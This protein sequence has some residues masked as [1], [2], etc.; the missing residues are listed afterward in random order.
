MITKFITTKNFIGRLLTI[1]GLDSTS[2]SHLFPQM[3]EDAISII[4][5]PDYYINKDASIPIINH[6]GQLPCDIEHAHSFWVGKT[7][8][9]ESNATNLCRLII[10]NNPLIGKAIKA[11]I[12]DTAYGTTNGRFIEVTF[13][14]G[15]VIL[16]YKGL[17]CD[18]EG[19]PL[20]PSDADF[21][22]ALEYYCIMRLALTG[23]KHPILDYNSAYQLWEKH[24]PRAGNSVNWMNLEEY[25]EFTEMWNNSILGD[26]RALNYIH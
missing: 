18:E 12:H 20:V 26:L 14:K 24:Y 15:I 9:D 7:L 13:E 2:Y 19:F 23:Y 4:G 25:Q 11:P 5:I 10:R 22:Q 3:I 21:L 6:K 1:Y 8:Y 17:P 16:V